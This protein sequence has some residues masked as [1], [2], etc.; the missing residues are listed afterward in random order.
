MP[1]G[2]SLSPARRIFW[3]LLGIVCAGALVSLFFLYLYLQNTLAGFYLA[4]EEARLTRELKLVAEAV[5][6][7][8]SSEWT[9]ET[10][11]VHADR[12]GMTLGVGVAILA[13]DGKMLGDSTRNPAEIAALPSQ[14]DRPEIL[15]AMQRQVGVSLRDSARLKAKV[16]V[17]AQTVGGGFVR[18]EVPLATLQPPL[19]QLSRI[20]LTG[21]I[22]ALSA[23]LVL[24]LFLT[25]LATRRLMT[26]SDHA[27]RLAAGDLSITPPIAAHDELGGLTE[28]LN[29]MATQ[30]SANLNRLTEES[31]QLKGILEGITEGVMVT[32][33]EGRITLVNAAF[34]R[35]FRVASLPLRPTPLEY[36]RNRAINDSIR[37]ALDQ[38][39]E[40]QQEIR[41]LA[42]ADERLFDVYTAPLKGE[43]GVEGSV[44]IFHDTT[45]IRYLENLRQELVA[46]VSHEFKT[47]LTSILGY[48][49]TLLSEPPPDP[50]TTRRFAEK[51][52]KHALHLKALVED[53]LQVSRLESGIELLQLQ[54]TDM[55]NLIQAVVTDFQD[56]AK[57]RH[58][59]LGV[60]LAGPLNALVDPQAWQRILANLIDNALK[61]TPENGRVTVTAE[62]QA[63]HLIIRVADTGIGIPIE[64]QPRIF[65]RFYR[66]D[67]GRSREQ[68][69]TGLGLAIVKH[70]VHA[71]QGTIQV[72][73]QPQ[74]GAIFTLK[75]PLS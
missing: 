31:R 60:K 63:Q 22:I 75:I 65:E 9:P 26:V 33:R 50:D 2:N 11:D 69:G 18:F 24:A 19:M 15:Q 53:V 5:S 73:S 14:R 12:L 70:L 1:R 23:G 32:D 28:S 20:L 30:L 71:H 29:V 25:R 48:G 57:A 62:S 68:G 17:L 21:M 46:N 64:D 55:V 39:Q 52:R 59:T 4:E 37:A 7:I 54:R 10:L 13:A 74:A 67:K 3:K 40:A 35:L 43:R 27:R 41:V 38:E 36:F 6:H 66:A 16:F 61:Y 51:I 47:P 34:K 49:E 8:P 72:I 42:G 44:S 58:Q 45:Q 56:K